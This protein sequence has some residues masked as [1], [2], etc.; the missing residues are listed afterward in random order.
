MSIDKKFLTAYLSDLNL[1]YEDRNFSGKFKMPDDLVDLDLDA[2][3]Y[4][5]R[6]NNR[7]FANCSKEFKKMYEELFE[8]MDIDEENPKTFSISFHFPHDDFTE[9]EKEEF[10]EEINEYLI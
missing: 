8:K 3:E 4:E 2:E 6:V 10:L 9:D 5:Y 7:I 1:I